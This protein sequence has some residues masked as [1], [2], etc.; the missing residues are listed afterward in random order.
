LSF[1]VEGETERTRQFNVIG[2]PG[3]RQPA[4]FFAMAKQSYQAMCAECEQLWK[5]Y[6]DAS[7][8]RVRAYGNLKLANLRS[9]SETME[10]L[11]EA[12]AL[13]TQGLEE[14]KKRIQEHQSTRHAFQKP[15]HETG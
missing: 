1:L 5:D 15:I 14:V 2:V 6:G 8:E 12:A 11:A 7:R 3:S 13:A 9:D 10:M 4:L